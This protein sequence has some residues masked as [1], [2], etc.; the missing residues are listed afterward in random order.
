MKKLLVMLGI[1]LL[2]ASCGSE[3]I[4]FTGV[5]G[6]DGVDGVDGVDGRDGFNSLVTFTR[7]DTETEVCESGSGFLFA[8]GLDLNRNGVLDMEEIIE[9]TV[10]AVCDGIPGP[11]GPVGPMG[12]QGPV[13]AQ[14]PQGVVG[15]QGETGPQGEQ[16][17]AGL[18]GSPG[19]DALVAVLDPCGK[20]SQYDEVFF[21]F[22]DGKIYAVY[23]HVK[24]GKVH[25]V[26]MVPGNWVTT[27]GTGC[28]FTVTSDYEIVNEH[29]GPVPDN[30]VEDGEDGAPGPAGPMGPQG[31]AGPM[32]PQGPAGPGAEWTVFSL[33]NSCQSV[34]SG[35]YAERSG[36]TGAKLFDDH[37]CRGWDMVESLSE[38][39]DEVHIIGSTMF[40][41]DGSKLYKL[42]F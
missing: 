2:T 27:D 1:L 26:Q 6:R 9:S 3:Q 31:A 22:S 11:Q 32:G 38:E 5:D 29:N 10:S 17:I 28:Y 36:L 24:S 23:A 19:Q 21:E 20:Q 35:L 40:I 41:V 12:P 37:R 18:P 30:G 16:G 15:P 4:E 25:L 39:S 8:S 34:G 42:E 7:L 13:G 33:N 14:G